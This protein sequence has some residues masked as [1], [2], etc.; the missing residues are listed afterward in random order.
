MAKQKRPALAD[1]V[2]ALKE[3]GWRQTARGVFAPAESVIRPTPD[4][5]PDS[6]W[7]SPTYTDF[8]VL[9]ISAME[10]KPSHYWTSTGAPWVGAAEKKVNATQAIEFIAE[11]TRLVAEAKETTP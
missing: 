6:W 3:H 1:V 9:S 5:I 11:T 8:R 2:A 4:Y 10:G 7:G